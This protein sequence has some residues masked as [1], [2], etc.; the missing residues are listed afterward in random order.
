[1]CVAAASPFQLLMIGLSTVSTLVDYAAQREYNARLRNS[2]LENYYQQLND[3]Q[4]QRQEIK[5]STQTELASVARDA[6]ARRGHIR[7]AAG[8]AGVSGLIVDQLLQDVDAQAGFAEGNVIAQGNRQLAQSY[9]SGQ[10]L[11]AQTKSKLNQV[12]D[13]SLLGATL[14]IVGDAGAVLKDNPSPKKK[15]PSSEPSRPKN[16]LVARQKR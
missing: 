4:A 9:R 13:P 10:G 7:A 6:L 5:Q 3:L 1:M 16:P 2:Y 8:E 12:R 11:Y 14:K 15:A